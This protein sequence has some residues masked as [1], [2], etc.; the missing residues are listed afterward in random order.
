MLSSV[1][2]R[3]IKTTNYESAPSIQNVSDNSH[4]NQEGRCRFLE[5][6][7]FTTFDSIFS[8]TVF[9]IFSTF[10]NKNIII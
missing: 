7:L 10:L 3:L 1:H 2:L 4:G 6:K 5:I 9:G 8:C